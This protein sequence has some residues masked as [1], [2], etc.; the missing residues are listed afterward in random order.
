M[1]ERPP[2]LRPAE[3]DDSSDRRRKVSFR[4][5]VSPAL[6]VHVVGSCHLAHQQAE[7]LLEVVM[8]WQHGV[9]GSDALYEGEHPKAN[10]VIPT[11]GGKQQRRVTIPKSPLESPKLQ[12][13]SWNERRVKVQASLNGLL[14]LII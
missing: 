7:L 4:C 13:N 11:L 14:P 6:D 10:F 12:G 8:L 3:L 1:G 5:E 9:H 2:V